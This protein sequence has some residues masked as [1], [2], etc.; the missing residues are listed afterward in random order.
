MTD[1]T[2]GLTLRVAAYAVCLRG[3][4]ML[5]ARW[6]SRDGGSRHWT[7]PGGKVEHGEDPFTAVVREVEE[8]TGYAVEVESLLGV[9]SRTPRPS[10]HNIGVY[11]LVRVVGGELRN[12]TD[13][14]TD[15]AEWVAWDDVETRKR[16]GLVDIARALA[17]RRPATGHVNPIP[18]GGLV[19]H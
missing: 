3:D 9:D 11:Y 5:L 2:P 14:S 18:V 6:V 7:L 17:R 19:R 4:E 13:G 12:E 15:L 16:S 1:P 8:E 10:H